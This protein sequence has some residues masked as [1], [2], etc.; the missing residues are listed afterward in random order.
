MFGRR[1]SSVASSRS[2]AR[3]ITADAVKE[4]GADAIPDPL[5]G[6]EAVPRGRHDEEVLEVEGT[7]I[8]FVAA[9][10]HKNAILP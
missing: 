9:A 6:H 5:P 2:R 4:A 7:G 8:K 1:E 10:L 3:S